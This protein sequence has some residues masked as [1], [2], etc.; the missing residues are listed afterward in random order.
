MKP[1]LRITIVRLLLLIFS[2][3]ALSQQASGQIVVTPGSVAGYRYFPGGH[4]AGAAPYLYRE[5]VGD[6]K[7]NTMS[8][9]LRLGDG[10]VV[11]LDGGCTAPGTIAKDSSGLLLSC[12]SGRWRKQGTCVP[13]SGDLNWLQT[14]GCYNGEKLANAPQGTSDWL[15]VEVLRHFNDGNYFTVQRATAM[16]GASGVEPGQVW[17]RSQQSSESGQSW[18]PWKKPGG[19]QYFSGDLN[20]L[21]KDGCYNGRDL[22][23]A[24]TNEWIFVEVLRHPNL[25]NYHV[26]QRAT[27]MSGPDS[28]REW[29][30]SE[31]SNDP[32]QR[33]GP[34]R[35]SV[36]CVYAS[37]SDLN[38]IQDDGCYN[39]DRLGNAPTSEWLFV[40]VM[41]HVNL[42]VY[43]TIQRATKMTGGDA[44]T[45]WIRS[46]QSNW[47]NQGWGEWKKQGGDF[48]ANAEYGV[49]QQGRGESYL[50]IGSHKACFL[51]RFYV[52]GGEES[53]DKWCAVYPENNYWVLMA[54]LGWD[55]PAVYKTVCYARCIDQ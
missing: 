4:S 36:G 35:K 32:A 42:G 6:P 28:G 21:N 41:R 5:D 53:S 14:G 27:V 3:L 1:T 50:N 33:W 24:P 26:I 49:T 7:L 19:C 2:L 22:G 29:I 47:A 20:W 54:T 12:Q 10:T 46:Q 34:W 31:Q 30:R 51:S 38:G 11:T 23:N 37:G 17:I 55:T 13:F 45:V 25:T 43:Y 52:A 8:T 48:N 15:F 39:G 18:G 40:E 9:P 16:T 44:G